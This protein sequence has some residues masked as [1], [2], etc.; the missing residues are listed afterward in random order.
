MPT[1]KEVRVGDT[2]RSYDFPNCY[3]D[4]VEGAVE[5]IGPHPNQPCQ[6]YH[7]RVTREVARDLEVPDSQL[8]GQ[9]VYAPLNGTKTLFGGKTNG[10]RRV[11][12]KKEV[13]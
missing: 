5:A 13:A 12:P 3:T 6:A 2:V 7:I 1:R 8:V 9:L 11:V 4:Y 10:V